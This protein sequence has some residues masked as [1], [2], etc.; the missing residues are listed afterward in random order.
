[1]TLV[2]SSGAEFFCGQ[3]VPA[4]RSELDF[5]VEGLARQAEMESLRYNDGSSWF[6]TAASTLKYPIAP[7]QVGLLTRVSKKTAGT[8]L[9]RAKLPFGRQ[10]G[11][12]SGECAKFHRRFHANRA[13]RPGTNPANVPF[14][15]QSGETLRAVRSVPGCQRRD[16]SQGVGP[17][18]TWRKSRAPTS[19]RSARKP[20]GRHL[21]RGWLSWSG[22]REVRSEKNNPRFSSANRTFWTACP[23]KS[24][25]T[26][27]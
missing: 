2:N 9:A 25:E 16:A 8:I 22:A 20:D 26:S 14:G 15:R 17:Q 11:E 3:L 27:L 18:Q 5:E 12:K 10:S 13:G 21:R 4:A 1:M 19:A 23:G 7:P 6:A 24:G